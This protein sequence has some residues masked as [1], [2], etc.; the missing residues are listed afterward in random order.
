MVRTNRL[1]NRFQTFYP[2]QI[3]MLT[4]ESKTGMARAGQEDVYR[5]LSDFNN[6][7]HLLPEEKMKDLQLSADTIFSMDEIGQSGYGRKNSL[8]GWLSGQLR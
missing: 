6:F 3:T 5:Y 8:F 2:T 1:I 7:K 4:I